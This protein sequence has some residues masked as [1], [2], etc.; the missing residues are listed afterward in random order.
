MAQ[1]GLPQ[2]LRVGWILHSLLEEVLDDPAKNTKE[3]LATRATALNKL[4]DEEL[5]G[6]MKRAREKEAEAEAEAE[7]EIKKDFHVK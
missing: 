4:S 5:I 3:Y 7:A 2:S 6:I 1:L